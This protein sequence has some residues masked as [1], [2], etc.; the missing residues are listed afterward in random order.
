MSLVFS[1]SEQFICRVAV[2]YELM[3]HVKHIGLFRLTCMNYL[4]AYMR[5]AAVKRVIKQT[6]ER[7]G[8]KLTVI[9]VVLDEVDEVGD[10]CR[11]FSVACAPDNSAFSCTLNNYLN[12]VGVCASQ[13]QPDD[14]NGRIVVAVK[15]A[16]GTI[17]NMCCNVNVEVVL[18][19][20]AAAQG[21]TVDGC[22]EAIRD[23]TGEGR[24]L[25]TL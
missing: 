20:V 22:L 12:H 1:V 11:T 25:P 6:H 18:A 2:L 8:T 14:E 19:T 7:F 16:E 9:P 21:W 4:S 13:W 17:T 23:T 10:L 24:G 5:C 15:S 3:V